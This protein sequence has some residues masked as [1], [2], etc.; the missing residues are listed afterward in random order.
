MTKSTLSLSERLLER[1]LLPAGET[2]L[3]GVSGGVDSSL[4]ATI[5]TDAL[6]PQNVVA[7]S[8]P[9]RYSSEGSIADARRVADTLGIRLMIIPI[10]PAHAAY[11]EVLEDAFAG[12]EPGTAEE[13]IQSR[14]RG[15]IWM[16]LSNKVGWQPVL[17]CGNKSEMACG[18]ATLYGDM[19][20]GF[21]VIKDVLKTLVYKV[22]YYRNSVKEVIPHAVLVKPPTA[23]LRPN[24]LDTDSLPSYDILDPILQAYVEED[25]SSHEIVAMGFDES[26][27][28]R[29]IGLVDNSEYKRRQA[30]PGIK[31]TPRAFGKD[32]RLPITSGYRNGR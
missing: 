23:E 29:V 25:K 22:S 3:V 30:P 14:I 15:N 18:Y 5:A 31:I 19:A 6:G 1:G 26:T 2:I 11:L 13:N 28:K 24:Q 8:N 10:E 16:A 27:V 32:R 21:A 20:G 4:V 7:V 17:T 12:T 9:S